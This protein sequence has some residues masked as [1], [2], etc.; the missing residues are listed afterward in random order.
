MKTTRWAFFFVL[1]GIKILSIITIY[2]YYV[3]SNLQKI[4]SH[5]KTQGTF[6]YPYVISQTMRNGTER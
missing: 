4:Y 3:W 1:F 5:R 6:A 2:K